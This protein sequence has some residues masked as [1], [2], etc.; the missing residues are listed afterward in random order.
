MKMKEKIERIE[1]ITSR[2]SAGIAPVQVPSPVTRSEKTRK[3]TSA[4]KSAPKDQVA[5]DKHRGSKTP[6]VYSRFS[7]PPEML[8]NSAPETKTQA[9]P[10]SEPKVKNWTVLVYLA[11]DCNLEECMV[12]D[13]IDMEK[14][15][16][17]K[18]MNIVAQIDRG[19]D[20]E[21]SVK[22]H[23]GVEGA[24]RYLVEKN[25]RAV[26]NPLEG[27]TRYNPPPAI[28]FHKFPQM[29]N[30]IHSKEAQVLGETN[31]SDPKVLEDFLTWGMKEYP[32]K[33]YL[34]L[35][36]GHG[37][38]ATGLL[39]DDGHEESDAISLPAFNQAVMNAE[40]AAGVSKEQVLLGMKSCLMGQAETAY[41]L[42]D[43]GSLLINS[44]SV[45]HGDS[46]R[47]DDI[48]GA[49]GVEDMSLP[50]MAGNIFMQNREGKLRINNEGDFNYRY[51]ITTNAIVDLH[52]MPALKQAVLMFK[53]ALSKT[54]TDPAKLKEILEVQSRPGF[55]TNTES[56]F[57]ASDL[58]GAAGII[59]VDPTIQ[60]QYLK[61]SAN[62][63]A[64]VLTRTVIPSRRQDYEHMLSAGIGMVTASDPKFYERTGYSDLALEKDTGWSEFMSNYAQ[65]V[66]KEEMA[67][68]L[69]GSQVTDYRLTLIS[70][71]A[72]KALGN[73]AQLKKEIAAASKD[74]K[75]VNEDKTLTESEQLVKGIERI[76]KIG[77]MKDLKEVLDKSLN[78][79]R[80]HWK[81]KTVNG[82]LM[83]DIVVHED[84]GTPIAFTG[85]QE[86]VGDIFR[87]MLQ[88]GSG[89]PE[90]L[91]A[92]VRAGFEVLSAL[93]GEIS[94]KTLAKGAKNLLKA[95]E[96]LQANLSPAAKGNLTRLLREPDMKKKAKKQKALMEKTPELLI[97]GLVVSI[98]QDMLTTLGAAA[99]DQKMTN[100][101]N[102]NGNDR[103]TYLEDISK[104]TS[105][106]RHRKV[107]PQTGTLQAPGGTMRWDEKK[108]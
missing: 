89:K 104:M 43:A 98:G 36:Y 37:S 84:K 64:N 103:Q 20:K 4:A 48:L 5:L 27:F 100:L 10:E 102:Y 60:D 14:V 53:D 21:A 72:K 39:T 59:M 58:L 19:E 81:T 40:K 33:N 45:I 22:K 28:P 96:E 80:S 75:A 11:A 82:Q 9:E 83:P 8:G 79:D 93:D 56:S 15:G 32:A 106:P 66:T 52:A 26:T 18:N 34:V 25:P 68:R 57:N 61:K 17:S 12:G 24:A 88:R 3:K 86:V 87:T 105:H 54:N 92:F 31:T 50:E 71:T 99:H 91:E 23:G 35:A 42:K 13:L 30:T 63:L 69:P 90:Y 7:L 67:E 77:A 101:K 47:M 73:Q 46:W 2:P 76:I 74:I 38:G 65:D 44:Q 97:P 94:T 49:P 41:E 55:F 62:I 107:A 108:F 51:A 29:V 70:D 6:V 95:R 85:Y 16:S 78:P 1:E